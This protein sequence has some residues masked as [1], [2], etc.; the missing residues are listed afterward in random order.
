MNGI[1]KAREGADLS[2][3]QAAT[4]LGMTAANLRALED[5]AFPPTAAEAQALARLYGAALSQPQQ[6]TLPLEDNR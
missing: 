4:K 6:L 5:G 3:H 1:R 2:L